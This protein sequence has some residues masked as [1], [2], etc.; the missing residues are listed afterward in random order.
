MTEHLRL[1]LKRY[2]RARAIDW[3]GHAVWALI[4]DDG[5]ALIGTGSDRPDLDDQP[6]LLLSIA[7][8]APL[9]ALARS[10]LYACSVDA[11]R[12][13][14][15]LLRVDRI[16]L[17]AGSITPRHRHAGPGIRYLAQGEI[18]AMVGRQRFLVRPGQA[19]LERP[20]DDIIGRAHPTQ[21][22]VFHRFVILPPSLRGG[23]TSFIPRPAEPT[24]PKDAPFERDQSILAERVLAGNGTRSP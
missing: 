20:E 12:P 15:W 11:P 6:V 24:D 1:H 4:T 23:T 9:A 3:S 22:A 21:G 2:E 5:R 19:W 10:G 8:S 16:T 13:D 14:G 18:D 7:I 17:G